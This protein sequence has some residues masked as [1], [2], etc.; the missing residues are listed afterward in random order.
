MIRGPRPS[1]LCSAQKHRLCIDPNCILGYAESSETIAR[2]SSGIVP[3]CG[4][5]AIPPECCFDYCGF[6]QG[7]TSCGDDVG[8]EDWEVGG[9]EVR[10]R[11]T[12][13]VGGG[14]VG[15]ED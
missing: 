11:P 1:L 15:D 12:I 7:V 9:V 5:S 10:S 4:S 8:D 14:E 13:V 3:C 6:M 2:T